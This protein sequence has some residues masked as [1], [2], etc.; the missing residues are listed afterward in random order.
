M[1][2]DSDRVCVCV[3]VLVFTPPHRPLKEAASPPDA[4][5]CLVVICFL[6]GSLDP[7]ESMRV[8]LISRPWDLVAGARATLKV[9][10]DLGRLLPALFFH[11]EGGWGL[12]LDYCFP[13][14]VSFF[15][16]LIQAPP[17]GVKLL[18]LTPLVSD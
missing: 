5:M 11:P 14:V 6:G 12:R 9:G 7:D 15:R 3:C 16:P 1:M 2:T 13:G 10:P 17:F 8:C 4:N 18:F